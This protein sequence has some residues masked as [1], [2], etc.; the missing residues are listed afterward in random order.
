MLLRSRH[1]S[2]YR[3][4]DARS[5]ISIRPSRS[6]HFLS[7]KVRSPR[8]MS[9][10]S[11]MACRASSIVLVDRIVRPTPTRTPSSMNNPDAQRRPSASGVHVGEVLGDKGAR[12][13]PIL[14]RKNALFYGTLNG[15][16]VGD[17]FMSLIDTWQLCDAN[18][19]DYLTELQRHAQEAA[20]KPAEWMPWNYYETLERSVPTSDS[21]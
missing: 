11:S 16:D 17:L 10:S 12:S 3:P 9:G 20:S 15:A 5:E 21:A 1:Q 6:S 4:T 19:F 7:S 18:S 13:G 8:L 2:E 14:H